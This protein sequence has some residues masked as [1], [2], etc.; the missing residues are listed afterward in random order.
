MWRRGFSPGKAGLKARRYIWWNAKGQMWC[1]G[2]S[3]RQGQHA[4]RRLNSAHKD[5]K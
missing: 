5:T 3:P 1:R 4:A 2:F